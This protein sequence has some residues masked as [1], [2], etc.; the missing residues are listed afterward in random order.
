MFHRLVQC[1]RL[2]VGRS[3]VLLSVSGF[4]AGGL[5]LRHAGRRS[6]TL[7]SKIQSNC[8]PTR[9]LSTVPPSKDGNL[10]YCGSLGSAV[11]GVKFFSYTT[12]G[13]SLFLMPQIFLRTGLGVESFALQVVFC[14]IIGFFTFMT[15]VLLHLISK[16]YVIRLYHNSDTDTYTAITYSVFLTEKRRV[17]HQSQDY[18]HLMGYDKPFTFSTDDMDASDKN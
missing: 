11:R 4:R 18:N 13:I 14:G 17:F 12:S 2:T 9:C 10:I 1:V 16:G 5:W 15:P 6:I 7:R 8:L 3:V